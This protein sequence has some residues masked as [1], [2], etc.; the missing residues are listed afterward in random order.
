MKEKSS[1]FKPSTNLKKNEK[2]HIPVDISDYIWYSINKLQKIKVQ[3]ITRWFYT[4]L[5]LFIVFICLK[6]HTETYNVHQDFY[7]QITIRMVLLILLRCC[8]SP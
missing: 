7:I 4:I 6:T 8:I 5:E 3:M 1:L 2:Q